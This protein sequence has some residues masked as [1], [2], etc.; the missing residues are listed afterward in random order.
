MRAL[1]A[2]SL[3]L[4]ATMTM[5]SPPPPSPD[6]GLQQLGSEPCTDA[7]TLQE[8]TCYV[9]R[10]IHDNIYVS[11]LQE[12]GLMFIRKLVAGGYETIWTSDWFDAF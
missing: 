7:A 12:Q 2:L 4:S 6:G 3:V 9:S 5:A 1:L 8:G 10:D 11:F